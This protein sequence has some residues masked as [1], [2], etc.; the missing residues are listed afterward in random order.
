M[1]HSS[2]TARVS[3][4]MIREMPYTDMLEMN[5]WVFS[6]IFSECLFGLKRLKEVKRV[7]V[8][9]VWEQVLRATL[10]VS[11]ISK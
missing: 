10:A 2:L 3:A 5:L 1:A 4:L 11:F 6:L 9:L 7:H 8:G